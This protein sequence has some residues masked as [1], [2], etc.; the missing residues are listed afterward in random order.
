MAL[1]EEITTI[2]E[3][4]GEV[5]IS[6]NAEEVMALAL[7]EADNLSAATGESLGSICLEIESATTKKQLSGAFRRFNDFMR[8]FSAASSDALNAPM[9][10]RSVSSLPSSE[11]FKE[12]LTSQASLSE[13]VEAYKSL[14]VQDLAVS[15][16]RQAEA[17]RA[18]DEGDRAL[19]AR[20][21]PEDIPV[22][23]EVLR[24]PDPASSDP[25]CRSGP[26]RKRVSS[27]VGG[28]G[29]L[30]I[31]P[32]KRKSSVPALATFDRALEDCGKSSTDKRTLMTRQ[33]L[34]AGVDDP[35]GLLDLG[36]TSTDALER[37]KKLELLKN[38]GYNFD[39]L[40]KTFPE[41]FNAA[42][43]RLDLGLGGHVAADTLVLGA[44]VLSTPGAL[45]KKNISDIENNVIYGKTSWKHQNAYAMMMMAGCLNQAKRILSKYDKVLFGPT[46]EAII[47]KT[48]K[49]IRE[50]LV[51]PEGKMFS[52]EQEETDEEA[53]D[54]CDL[55]IKKVVG[56]VPPI[57]PIT[58][59][60]KSLDG[61]YLRTALHFLGAAEFLLAQY[62]TDVRRQAN[63]AGVVG[64][65][66][67][68]H[69]E[70]ERCT[71]FNEELK[72]LRVFMRDMKAQYQTSLG[73]GRGFINDAAARKSAQTYR[74]GRGSSYRLRGTLSGRGLNR[75]QLGGGDTY[76]QGNGVV[77]AGRG[78]IT[79]RDR[80]ICFGYQNG[81][82]RRGSTCRF[83][84]GN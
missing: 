12:L 37:T 62:E 26:H 79:P 67:A 6:T 66:G 21:L 4:N 65:C 78:R 18:D 69:S 82:C 40:G 1:Q 49:V 53:V 41:R 76:H 8:I 48:H 13:A 71:I 27:A 42:T 33:R 3:G 36:G 58:I 51:S 2:I 22:E 32:K 83:F 55:F 81:T 63:P 9:V 39:A 11:R 16:R 31:I 7:R 80:G 45:S 17:R 47:E 43:L 52:K 44:K 84:H 19:F 10:L 50:L 38:A 14:V 56:A 74:R 23:V 54:R 59:R 68:M 46:P 15:L 30:S 34:R 24:N 77:G 57:I 61:A 75:E 70:F 29:D 64:M 60:N 25:V 73:L 35:K 28:I 72:P 20:F 5:N